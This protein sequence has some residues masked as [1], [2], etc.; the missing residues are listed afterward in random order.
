MNRSAEI[1]EQRDVVVG[2][3]DIDASD[4]R[5]VGFG[6][7]VRRPQDCA[8]DFALAAPV[9]E[10][11]V[12]IVATFCRSE[13]AITANISGAGFF[14]APGAAAAR[15]GAARGGGA[16]V[17]RC[18]RRILGAG[19][20]VRGGAVVCGRARGRGRAGVALD[21]GIGGGRWTRTR[22]E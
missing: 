18:R 5:E 6:D 21:R 1:A 4:C 2:G 16:G 12:A 19:V 8:T 11:V 7:V 14:A 9:A 3:V 20:G 17:G 15:V 22:Q 13:E 10:N